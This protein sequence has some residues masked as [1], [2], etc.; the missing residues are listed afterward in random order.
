MTR[1][2]EVAKMFGT[3]DK[4]ISSLLLSQVVTFVSFA[5]SYLKAGQKVLKFD[6]WKVLKLFTRT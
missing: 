3:R 4:A 1:D 2:V 5:N 6:F